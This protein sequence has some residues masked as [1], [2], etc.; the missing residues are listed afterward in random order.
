MSRLPEE[1]LL[2]RVTDRSASADDWDAIECL[3]RA[4]PALWR[5]LGETLRN[6]CF[7]AEAV[8]EPG[9]VAARVDLPPLG[10]SRKGLAFTWPRAIAA[11]LLVAA[12]LFWTLDAGGLF[13]EDGDVDASDREPPPTAVSA[14]SHLE[15]YLN[16][17]LVEGSVLQELPH[18]V[19]EHRR[20]SDGK[21]LEVLFVRRFLERKIVEQAFRIGAD[22]QGRP[23]ASPVAARDLA[24]SAS[25]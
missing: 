10:L 15:N 20:A 13:P 18:L 9:A 14:L 19:L 12:L 11:S 24:P 8:Q 23:Q 4:D 25:L 22:E 1:V 17:G 5:R 16:Q 6:D 3:G 7:L 2:S 21:C